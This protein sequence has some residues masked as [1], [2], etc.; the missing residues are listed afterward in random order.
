METATALGAG[1]A[2]GVEEPFLEGAEEATFEAGAGMFFLVARAIGFAP[3]FA[4]PAERAALD[5]VIEAVK[6]LYF[7]LNVKVFLHQIRM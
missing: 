4:G 1:A 5:F 3:F 2:L 6:L 7:A